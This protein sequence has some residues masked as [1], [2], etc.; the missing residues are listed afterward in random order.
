MSRRSA[1]NG[2]RQS[3]LRWWTLQSRMK[4]F[5]AESLFTM[6]GA[7]I[8]PPEPHKPCHLRQLKWFYNAL[9][10]PHKPCRPCREL[11]ESFGCLCYLMLMFLLSSSEFK[12]IQGIWCRTSVRCQHGA[13]SDM[14]WNKPNRHLPSLV[15][16][17]SCNDNIFNLLMRFGALK[18]KSGLNSN[19]SSNSGVDQTYLV[20]F[21]HE[22]WGWHMPS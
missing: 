11:G 2:T 8:S 5:S 6:S 15:V 19:G 16:V 3:C 18:Q 10:M 13:T 14:R 7:G 21:Y 22:D 12:R 20:P 9:H 1:K 17:A 4:S